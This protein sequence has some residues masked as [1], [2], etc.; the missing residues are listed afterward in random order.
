MSPDVQIRL[1]AQEA[2]F[3]RV[4]DEAFYVRRL[5]S[6]GIEETAA[7]DLYRFVQIGLGRCLQAVKGV[8]LPDTFCRF[9][10][11]GQRVDAGSLAG[12]PLFVEATRLARTAFSPR[13]A[14]LIGY[15]SPEVRTTLVQIALGVR[16][17]HVKLRPCI[18]FT[19]APT[20]GLIEQAK[21]NIDAHAG[22][23]AS[24]RATRP[25]WKRW[26]AG[27]LKVI[28]PPHLRLRASRS[29]PPITRI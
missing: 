25:W 28:L 13:V 10:A 17:K 2:N 1:L 22:A 7:L 9:D 26:R 4:A 20:P 16:P 14:K 8:Q 15:S 19:T 18:L 11:K 21:R 12:Q 29:S 6:H 24:P 23:A 3:Y 27:A 5:C